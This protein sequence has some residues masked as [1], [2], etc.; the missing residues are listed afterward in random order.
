M[1]KY[2]G[3]YRSKAR[4]VYYTR[5]KE[6][7]RYKKS[8]LKAERALKSKGLEPY[9]KRGL[10]KWEEYFKDKDLFKESGSKN[11]MREVLNMQLYK[12]SYKQ[13]VALRAAINER[14]KEDKS[15][16]KALD[17]SFYEMRLGV[18]YDLNFLKEFWKAKKAVNSSLPENQKLNLRD[19]AD[20]F[21][22]EWFGYVQ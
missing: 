2:R 4:K 3:K 13:T 5:L 18:G 6:Y 10:L 16:E 8:Y 1:S 12:F 14:A 9:G 15:L 22:K 19:L 20:E 17:L 11:P 7:N 21:E